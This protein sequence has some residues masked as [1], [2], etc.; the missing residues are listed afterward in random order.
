M[1]QEGEQRKPALSHEQLLQQTKLHYAKQKLKYKSL[2]ADV[3]YNRQE[4]P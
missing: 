2:L 1:N 3:S 4:I